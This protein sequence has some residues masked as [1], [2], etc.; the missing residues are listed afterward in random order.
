MRA[1]GPVNLHAYESGKRLPSAASLKWLC[2]YYGL[3]FEE[4]LDLLQN[5][6]KIRDLA[7]LETGAAD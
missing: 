5:A 2:D 6:R 7:N 4:A 1:G 3:P